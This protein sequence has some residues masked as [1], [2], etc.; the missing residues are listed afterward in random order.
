MNLSRIVKILNENKCLQPNH[1]IF[2]SL[3]R[4]DLDS[5]KS[6]LSNP[7]NQGAICINQVLTRLMND[8]HSN[9]EFLHFY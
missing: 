1:A 2:D 8:A 6:I 4:H 9:R 7:D 3:A 5:F